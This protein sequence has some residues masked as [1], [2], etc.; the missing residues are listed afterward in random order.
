MRKGLFRLVIAILISL[1]GIT[2]SFCYAWFT[3]IEKSQIEGL[4][5]QLI[6]DIEGNVEI[7]EGEGDS[8]KGIFYFGSRLKYKIRMLRDVVN[9]KVTGETIFPTY[10]EFKAHFEEHEDLLLGTYNKCFKDGDNVYQYAYDIEK[11]EDINKIDFLFNF[12]INNDIFNAIDIYVENQKLIYHSSDDKSY[13]TLPNPETVFN[14]DAEYS[15]SIALGE[16]DFCPTY[17]K[18][19]ESFYYLTNSLNCFLLSRIN[20][21]FESQIV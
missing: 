2:V 16:N 11:D 19:N 17:Q 14:K 18:Q 9:L 20:L 13:F 3:T 8:S 1:L 21:S 15:L 6:D 12:L 10:G 5:F 7:I 4:S